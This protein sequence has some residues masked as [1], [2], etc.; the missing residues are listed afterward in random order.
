MASR[1]R[2]S[3]AKGAAFERAIAKRLT[4]DTGLKFQRGLG[5]TRAGGAEVADVHCEE[6]SDLIHIEVKRRK[7]CDIKAALRQ[8]TRDAPEKIKIILTKDDRAPILV[9]QKKTEWLGQE[10]GLE[11]MHKAGQRIRF[12]ELM[13]E[14]N[15]VLIVNNEIVTTRYENWIE[16][17]KGFVCRHLKK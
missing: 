7:K 10:D 3:R 13:T 6:L 9:T 4:E 5:Q 2:G 16:S 17:F 11:V 1:G 14:P 12:A 8:A 15:R